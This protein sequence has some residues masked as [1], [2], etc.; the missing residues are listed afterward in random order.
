[1]EKG[2]GWAASQEGSLT[3]VIYHPFETMNLLQNQATG[4]RISR[5]R[6]FVW[7]IEAAL[8]T[9]DATPTTAAITPTTAAIIALTS[10]GT[11][12]LPI[13]AITIVRIVFILSVGHGIA[14]VSLLIMDLDLQVYVQEDSKGSLPG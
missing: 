14:V 11:T 10:F 8:F 12:S 3:A 2:A 6:G 4:D 7:G 9:T 5:G 1:M 13:A